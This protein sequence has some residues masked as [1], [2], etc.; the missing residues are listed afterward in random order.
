[1]GLPLPIIPSLRIP[2]ATDILG[3]MCGGE[4]VRKSQDA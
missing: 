3:N 4:E 2:W 1:M